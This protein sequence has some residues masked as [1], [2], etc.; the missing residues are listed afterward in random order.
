MHGYPGGMASFSAVSSLLLFQDE[1][2]EQQGN[3]VFY[4]MSLQCQSK[5][6]NQ[7]NYSA[8]KQ[9]SCSNLHFGIVLSTSYKSTC[10]SYFSN[11]KSACV[12]HFQVT[13]HSKLPHVPI[14]LPHVPSYPTFQVTPCSKLPHVPIKLPHVPSNSTFQ[15][16]YPTFPTSCYYRLSDYW[17]RGQSSSIVI[18]VSG[19]KSAGTFPTSLITNWIVFP[20]SLITLWFTFLSCM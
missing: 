16:S 5:P 14:K 10:V 17:D 9:P 7:G 20:T 18:R 15:L 1:E 13:P 8:D 19:Y 2:K 11:Y 6:H 4:T 3:R 12:S